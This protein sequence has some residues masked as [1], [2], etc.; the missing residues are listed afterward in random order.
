MT[1]SKKSFSFG[2]DPLDD[3]L[4]AGW[5]AVVRPERSAAPDIDPAD[6]AL[7][8][9]FHTLETVPLPSPGFFGDLEQRL[10]DLSAEVHDAPPSSRPKR[11]DL[12]FSDNS[13]AGGARLLFRRSA[14]TLLPGRW[15]P[16]WS[17]AA[18][19]A[20]ILIASLFV[21]YQ[22]VPRTSEPP[23]I[24]AAAIA[25][26]AIEPIAQFEFAPPMWGMPD[27][28][29]W[30][31]METALFSV[32][33]ATSFTTELPWY[34]SA[35]GPLMIRILRGELSITPAGPAFVYSN[36]QSGQP[37]VEV[38]PGETVSMG[39]DDTIVYSTTDTAAGSNPGSDPALALY[40]VVGDLDKYLPGSNERPN[41]VSFIAYEYDTAIVP[42]ISTAGA[43]V[44]LQRLELAP[45]DTFVF[46]P[47]ADLKYVPLFD[48]AQTGDLHIA[49]GAL[50]GLVPNPGTQRLEEG[51]QLRYLQNKPH[52]IFNLGDQTV[53]IYFLV[54]EPAPDA[55]TPTP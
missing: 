10:A 15:N 38:A 19:L 3:P 47:D 17:A 43:T 37:P 42:R 26:P 53:E 13:G 35:E 23:P 16:L 31:H 50:E 7:L 54:V 8:R 32:A 49:D 24:P 41:D 46:D 45:F 5:D 9:R 48:P 36:N 20:V 33:P 11:R 4:V 14:G 22:A 1:A 39:P 27:A 30:T 34:T 52:T 21:V 55:A 28:T 29:A 2:R 6:V 51:F 44:T 40:G 18:V 12:L 25:K